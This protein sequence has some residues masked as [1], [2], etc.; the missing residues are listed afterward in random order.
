M[1]ES[2]NGNDNSAPTVPGQEYFTST[3]SQYQENVNN[4]IKVARFVA[5][6]YKNIPYFLGVELLN[7]PTLVDFNRASLHIFCTS[8]KQ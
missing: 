4:T 1:K 5:Q 6:C 2:K 8:L 7:E 3:R